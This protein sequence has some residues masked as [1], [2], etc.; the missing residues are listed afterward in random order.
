MN[1]MLVS[2]AERTREIELERLLEQ[3]LERSELTLV[4]VIIIGQLGQCRN[5]DGFK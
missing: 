5:C 3:A 1:I 4:E 2:V